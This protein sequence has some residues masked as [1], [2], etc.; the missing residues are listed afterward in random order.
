MLRVP[1]PAAQMGTPGTVGAAVPCSTGCDST[2]SP[3]GA[4]NTHTEVIA[5]IPGPPVRRAL[6]THPR[7][8]I[9][10]AEV[11]SVPISIPPLRSNPPHDGVGYTD[12]SPNPAARQ[13]RLSLAV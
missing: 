8:A 3:Q 1:N 2:H 11:P 13:V 12:V 4:T 6:L 7:K 5:A 9:S 10:G